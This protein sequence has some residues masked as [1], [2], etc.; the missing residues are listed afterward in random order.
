MHKQLAVD[1]ANALTRTMAMRLRR[2]EG[3]L[4]MLQE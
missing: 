1:L 2:V 3:K 4:A